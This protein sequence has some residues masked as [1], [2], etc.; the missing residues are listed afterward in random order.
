MTSR[1][2]VYSRQ[3]DQNSAENCNALTTSALHVRPEAKWLWPIMHTR[4]NV[5]AGEESKDKQN[6]RK[7]KT[8]Q[9][10]KTQRPA[11]EAHH[12][13]PS[14]LAQSS[15]LCRG[16]K[17][18]TVG[19]HQKPARW[20]YGGKE[21][22]AKHNTDTEDKTKSKRDKRDTTAKFKVRQ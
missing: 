16:W 11:G 10:E 6:K 17:S 22:K 4:C 8:S 1:S 15:V 7:Q 9:Q 21:T 5:K 13:R 14:M 18:C 19:R 20:S 2:L 12:V 3:A